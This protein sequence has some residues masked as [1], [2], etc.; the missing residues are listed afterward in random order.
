MNKELLNKVDDVSNSS[1]NSSEYDYEEV[2][3]KLE[4]NVVVEERLVSTIDIKTHS[5][6]FKMK[7]IWYDFPTHL[8]QDVLSKLNRFSDCTYCISNEVH[9]DLNVSILRG[10]IKLEQKR[11]CAQFLFDSATQW[12][13]VNGN[14]ETNIS[15][16]CKFGLLN[17]D[18]SYITKGMTYGDFSSNRINMIKPHLWQNKVFDLIKKDS[19]DLVIHWIVDYNHSGKTTLMK[20][21]VNNKNGIL[22]NTSDNILDKAFK[23]NSNLYVIDLSVSLVDNFPY[24]KIEQLKDGFYQINDEIVERNPPHIIILCSNPPNLLSILPHK[25]TISVVRDNDIIPFSKEY[26]YIK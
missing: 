26:N 19:N 5:P 17:K 20:Q 9:T 1:E 18:C 4:D 15:Y 10:Y 2:V 8:L 12:F 22:L 16:V 14:A 13:K 25:Y 21:L 24:D 6:W 7:F 11:R 3:D 23:F